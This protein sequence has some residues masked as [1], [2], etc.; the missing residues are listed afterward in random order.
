MWAYVKNLKTTKFEI[1]PVKNISNFVLGR[2]DKKFKIKVREE[3]FEG[4][5]VYYE[6]KCCRH[7]IILRV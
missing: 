2:F 3:E 5:I 1:V 4:V 7:F 6:G